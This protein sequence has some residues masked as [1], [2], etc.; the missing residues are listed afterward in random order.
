MKALTAF[1]FIFLSTTAFSQVF[2]FEDRDTW[3][4]GC[5]GNLVLEDFAGGPTNSGNTACDDAFSSAGNDCFPPGEIQPG[6]IITS[7]DTSPIKMAYTNVDFVSNPT[8]IVGTS[9]YEDFTIMRFPDG[10]INRVGMDLYGAPAASVMHVRLFGNAGDLVDSLTITEGMP[11]PYFFGFVTSL[12]ISS[13]EFQAEG[14]SVEMVGMVEFGTCNVVAIN[15]FKHLNLT[16]FPNPVTNTLTLQADSKITS[17]NVVN[18]L[19][20]TV[21]HQNVSNSKNIKLDVSDLASGT[22]FIKVQIDKK[23]ATYKMVKE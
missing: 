14:S 3:H 16:Y 5:E 22:Y 17:V 20:Q 23:Y 4:T 12:P 19:G 6:I 15:E 10:N 9:A 2:Y 1:L 8:P 13:I 18:V 7:S 21:V 11:G